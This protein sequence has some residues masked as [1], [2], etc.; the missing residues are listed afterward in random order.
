MSKRA[1]KEEKQ[2]TLLD[3]K[4]AVAKGNQLFPLNPTTS[5]SNFNIINSFSLLCT[6]CLLQA[7]KLRENP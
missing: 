6:M 7:K 4:K 3:M 1:K 5:S 2:Q